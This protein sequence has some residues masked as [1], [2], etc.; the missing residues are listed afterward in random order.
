M[1]GDGA[2]EFAGVDWLIGVD[3]CLGLASR[4]GD[5]E[6][7]VK[8]LELSLPALLSLSMRGSEPAETFFEQDKLSKGLLI[9][10]GCEGV[11]SSLNLSFFRGC[12][13]HGVE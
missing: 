13:G 1:K 3:S 10:D 8:E 5:T 2:R 11:T 12:E 6:S 9:L 7:S 4:P